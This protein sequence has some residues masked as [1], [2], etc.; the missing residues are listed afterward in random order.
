MPSLTDVFVTVR[1]DTEQLEPELKRK[2]RRIDGNRI[3][4]SIGKSIGGGM[5]VGIAGPLKNMA[6]LMTAAFAGVQIGGFLKDAIQQAS[7]LGETTSKVSQIFGPAARDIQAFAKD[8]ATALGQTQQ[9]ALDANATFG[10][11]GKSAGLSGKELSGFT[12]RFTTLASD[13]ASFNNTSP[14]EAIE[15]IGS[16]FRGEAEPMRR[17]GVL[18][19]DASLRQE[20]LKQGLISTT[21]DALTP[22]QKVL[23]AQALIL[24]KTKDAQGDFARTS[25]EVANQQRIL[26]AQFNN[27]KTSIGAVALPLVTRLFTFLNER[28]I[29]ALKGIGE[30]FKTGE[31]TAGG[32]AGFLQ[33]LG[34][35][36]GD[37][38]S[39]INGAADNMDGFRGVAQ[40]AGIAVAAFAG[41]F[42]NEAIPRIKEF[43]AFLRDEV[44]P[45]VIQFGRAL[46]RELVPMLRQMGV[47]IRDEILPR[48]VQFG[49]F[50]R[51]DVVPALGSLA[52]F[53]KDN[54]TVFEALF[55]VIAGGYVGFKVYSTAVAIHTGI[56][57]GITTATTLYAVAQKV[58]NG[59]LKANPIGLVITA[60]G[61]LVAGLIY[62]YKKSETFRK[63]VDGSFQA[64]AKAGKW[65]WE[66]VL[67][68]AFG[69]ILNTWTSVATGLIDTAAT[70]ADALGMDPLA[71]KLRK[72]SGAIRGFRD[73]FNRETAKL[74]NRKV[75]ISLEAKDILKRNKLRF[76]REH[77]NRPGGGRGGA[78]VD[79]HTA[80]GGLGNVRRVVQNVNEGTGELADAIVKKLNAAAAKQGG[81]PDFSGRY[82]FPLPRGSYRVGVP[83]NGY[84][85][86][87]GQDFPAPAGTPVFA[88]FSG[89]ARYVNLGNRSYGRYVS[90]RAGNMTSIQAHL[91]GFA[92]SP[93]FKRAGQLVGYV[94]STGNS[95]GNHLHQEFRDRGRVINPR[96]VL[97]FDS[98][99][100]L[101]RGLNLTYN[102]TRHPERIRTREQ[103]ASIERL[104]ALLERRGSAGGPVLTIGTMVAANPDEAIRKMRGATYDALA[105]NGIRAIATGG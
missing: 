87:T 3:G 44:V 83:I 64:V 25:G 28:G 15:A 53:V 76:D 2:L 47:F 34:Q 75:T 61:A 105:M 82:A 99:G 81:V 71:G 80:T 100:W 52:R 73:N 43:G 7:D 104:V 89:T 39:G 20:A 1:A 45:R 27:V 48:L 65:M 85:G 95:T 74:K 70:V 97:K 67:R 37:F 84:P 29:P 60:I 103:E 46:A 91:S 50:V 30:A 42:R 59:A 51:D 4:G 58:L 13:L 31:I 11:F 38:A 79:V 21:K 40:N 9:Q 23:A 98:G 55:A 88:P 54:R 14:E 90:L 66:R 101:P 68:P 102:G 77:T 24:A 93:G 41:W 18:L 35:W 63:I 96:N 19:D 49:G 26:S 22:Q 36:A 33:R 10:I 94:G 69:S 6:G 5:R 72:A 78:G 12:T 57:K 32:F 56:T 86:H 8:S 17:Y 62:A 92:G 16:A